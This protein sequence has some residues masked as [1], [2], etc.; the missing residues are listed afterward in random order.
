[1]P[2]RGSYTVKTEGV[3]TGEMKKR[4]DGHMVAVKRIVA[5]CRNETCPLPD[6]QFE[7]EVTTRAPWY[8]PGCVPVVAHARRQREQE[9]YVA[10]RRERER[11]EPRSR[12]PRR[13]IRYAGY[14][15]KE[16]P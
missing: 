2:K 9:K 11:E 10:K 6:K 13:L 8:C 4:A 14:D 7:C 5:T 15:G 16:R 12:K 3:Y 1:M